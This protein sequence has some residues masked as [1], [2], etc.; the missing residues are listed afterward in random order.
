[1]PNG[2]ILIHV[3]TR[4]IHMHV[5]NGAIKIILPNEAIKIILP[6]GA[7]KTILPNEAIKIIFP[8]GAIN[9]VMLIGAISGSWSSCISCICINIESCVSFE[10]KRTKIIELVFV[11]FLIFGSGEYFKLKRNVLGQ[12]LD[13]GCIFLFDVVIYY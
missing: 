3:P 12:F 13:N 7:I 1:M 11:S 2:T 6:N 5:P 4:A 9:I 10:K 8:N